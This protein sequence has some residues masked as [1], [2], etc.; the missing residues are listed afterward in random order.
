[1]TNQKERLFEILEYCKTKMGEN[2]WR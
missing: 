2:V 1:L